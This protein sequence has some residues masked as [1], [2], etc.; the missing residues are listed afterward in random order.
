VSAANDQF[1][2][3]VNTV[4][5]VPAATV[6]VVQTGNGEVTLPQ[7]VSSEFDGNT[8]PAGWHTSSWPGAVT[9]TTTVS[10]GVMTVDGDR[11]GTLAHYG[12]G[13]TLKFTATFSG[14][15]FQHGGFGTSFE[16]GSP[17]AIFS[18]GPGGA[19]YA[20]TT[21]GSGGMDT[22]LSASLLGSAHNYQID[23][24]ATGVTFSVDGSVVATHSTAVT[25]NMRPLFGD[26]TVGGGAVSVASIELVPPG[27]IVDFGGSALP[28]DWTAISQGAT[29][30]GGLLTV[31][32]DM[33]RSATAVGPGRS[34]EFLASFT[35]HPFQH[36]GFAADLQT[37]PWAIFSTFGG[38]Q[39]YARTN[40]GIGSEDTL[41]PGSWLGGPHLFRIDWSAAG[42]TYS[43]D[44][45]VVATHALSITTN[46][47]AA[48]SDLTGDGNLL[49]V[50]RLELS[51][52][53][54]AGA[55][56]SRVFD[57]GASTTWAN[58]SW[59]GSTPAGT[60]IAVTVRAG[61]TPT[62]DAS[63]TDF[64]PLVAA[65]A[66]APLIGRYI[67]YQAFLSNDDAGVPPIL[68]SV[69]I[70]TAGGVS[71]TDTTTADF[72][73]GRLGTGILA[74]DRGALGDPLK[75]VLI[76]GPANGTL[77]LGQDGSFTYTPATGFTGT[78]SFVYQAQGAD[79]TLSPQATVSILVQTAAHTPNLTVAN[80]TGNA[81]AQIALN[82]TASL[83]VT[84][85]SEVLSIIVTG[86]PAGATLN[87]GTPLGNGTWALA[88]GD[89]SGLTLIA[90]DPGTFTL[91]VTAISTAIASGATAEITLALVV[92][93]NTP[94]IGTA[95]LAGDPFSPGKQVL[96][97]IGTGVRDI[98]VVT[99][100]SVDSGSAL[101]V[102]IKPSGG[103]TFDNT[104]TG[105]ISRIVVRG[106]AG[107]DDIAV[108][109]IIT[110]P[111]WMYG[112]DGNDRM[113]GATRGHNVLSGGAG[114]DLVVGGAGRDLVIGGTGADRLIGNGGDDI[115]IAGTTAFDLNDVALHYIMAEWTSSHDFATRVANLRNTGTGLLSRLNANFFL[116]D[117]GPNKTV[118]N[119]GG[120]NTVSGGSGSDWMYTGAADQVA[121]LSAADRAFILGE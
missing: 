15:A 28:S 25:S 47:S 45:M 105:Q 56:Y 81:G 49:T 39:L 34:L 109:G 4:L 94:V 10:G 36:A 29:V 70:T 21:P 89:L 35:G 9:G 18:T 40:S 32:G 103:S 110:T 77:S 100:L 52:D 61:N 120:N 92:T 72:L 108:F 33:A 71:F 85:G 53:A 1:Q 30:G 79:G 19:L 60:A 73:A 3:P 82:I 13:R 121:D 7:S 14:D 78:D 51:A 37:G 67:Q 106:L 43:I 80:A 12:P 48:V 26:L 112:G 101:W 66:T 88:P 114:D 87:H 95:F 99:G 117:S 20:R 65:D 86:L 11:A 118:F 5:S 68:E 90:L 74:N 59:I 58:V 24:T 38:G 16:T 22:L 119:D 93:V 98:I 116:L 115:L 96:H 104:L 64:R 63:W 54:T 91:S 76:T 84:D 23:W 46:M 2:T 113:L 44:N 27:Y 111:V 41:L 17:W 57:S 107:N 8:L 62:P 50:D 69:T 97:V 55:F 102:V 83:A 6:L 75:A 31:D 42:V